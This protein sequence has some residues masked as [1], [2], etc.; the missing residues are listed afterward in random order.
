MTLSLR[1]FL[2]LAFASFIAGCAGQANL[3]AV[4]KPVVPTT[5][6]ECLASGGDWTTLG[7]P[8]AGKPAICDLKTKDAGRACTDSKYC[9]GVCLAPEEAA[10]GSSAIGNCSAYV[11]NFGNVGIITDGKVERLNVE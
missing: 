6:A 9:Q 2:C 3:T 7:I 5:E 8:Y 4:H 1:A 10:H 11:A